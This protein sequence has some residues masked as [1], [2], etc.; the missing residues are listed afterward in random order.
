[1][2]RLSLRNLLFLRLPW[3]VCNTH[4]FHNNSRS[5]GPS[6][7]SCKHHQKHPTKISPFCEPSKDDCKTQEDNHQNNNN[8]HNH[9]Y[10]NNK[11]GDSQAN[12]NREDED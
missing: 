1:M 12:N 8:K 2:F 9:L 5:K 7:R 11:K 10:P 4:K 6:P 3:L